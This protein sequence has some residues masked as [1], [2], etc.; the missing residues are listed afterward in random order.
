MMTGV[1]RNIIFDWSGTLVDDLPSVLAATNRVF[2][3][4]GV[5]EMTLDQFRAE[6]CLPFK[7]FYDRFAP[8]VPLEKLEACFHLHF[9]QMQELVI[10]LPHARD[11]LLFC[12]KH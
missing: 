12:R 7:N 9:A 11:F 3:E 4:N 2:A 10:E 1:I 8:G 5:D 6:F